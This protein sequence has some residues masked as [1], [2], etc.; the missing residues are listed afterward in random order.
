VDFVKELVLLNQP[1]KGKLW[2]ARSSLRPSLPFDQT[3]SKQEKPGWRNEAG[4]LDLEIRNVLNAG[5]Q[6][7]PG[8]HVGQVFEQDF[9]FGNDR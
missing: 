8:S 4:R 9:V 1:L 6:Q 7:F 3:V 5:P 2:S